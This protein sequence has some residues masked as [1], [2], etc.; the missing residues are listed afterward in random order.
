M[1][2]QENLQKALHSIGFAVS[3][4]RDLT[5]SDNTLLAD[6]ALDLLGDAVRLEQ[7]LA[8]LNSAMDAQPAPTSPGP[9]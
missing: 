8:R 1:N 4:L 2:D 7:R 3:D 5:A 9:R 6:V